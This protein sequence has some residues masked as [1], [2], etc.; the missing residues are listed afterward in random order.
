MTFRSAITTPAKPRSKGD[1]I[2]RA[3]STV[4]LLAGLVFLGFAPACSDDDPVDEFREEVQDEA[5]DA[6]DALEETGDDIGDDLDEA[7]EEVE[8]EVDDHS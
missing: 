1:E 2:R 3:V 5:D 8:D 7:K 4:L 6:R